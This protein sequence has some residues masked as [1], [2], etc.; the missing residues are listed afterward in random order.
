M[1]TYH[2]IAAV[3]QAIVGLL[4]D[5]CPRDEFPNAQFELQSADDVTKA[6]LTEGVSIYLYRVMLDGAMRNR[7]PRLGLDGKRYRRSLPVNLYYLAIPWAK[8][9]L[10]Q[11][12]LLGW[13]MRTLEDVPI[14]PSGLL[15]RDGF[16]DTFAID[17]AVE[18]FCEP[19]SLAD[20]N[21]VWDAFK[22]KIQISAPYVARMV[23]IDSVV[24]V[25]ET[26]PSAQ[27]RAYNF[28]KVGVP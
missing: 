6:Q 14:L 3:G 9:A 12:V 16:P 15:N 22:P 27:T 7:P 5:A 18:L 23:S 1:A 20:I 4:K 10:K 13:C 17:E 28:G 2:A 21:S 19:L 8:T 11:Q 26:G 25:A 24:G